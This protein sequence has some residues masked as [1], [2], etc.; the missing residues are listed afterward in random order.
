MD[1][2]DLDAK[3]QG[4]DN[5]FLI[6]LDNLGRQLSHGSHVAGIAA[7]I[8]NNAV[9]NGVAGV[10]WAARIHPKNIFDD[11]G[12]PD[13][14]QSIFDAVNFNANVWTLNNSWGLIQ[15]LDEFDNGIPGR[16]SVTVR[17]AFAHAY[18]NNRVSCIAM[19]NHQLVFGAGN[20]YANDVAFPAGFNTGSITVGA[21]NINDDIANFSAN[22]PH[23]DVAA[24]GV[25]IWSTNFNDNYIDLNGTSMATPYVAGLASLLK[26][27]N[28][29]LAND[30]IEQIIRLSADDANILTDPGFDNQ[31]GAGRIN[32]ER[33]LQ[34]LQAPNTLQQLSITGGTIN[35]T[36]GNMTRIF[37][38]V[39]GLA[40]AAY[41]VRGSEVRRNIAFPAMCNLIGVWGRGVGTTG[42]REE[43]GKVLVRAFAKLFREL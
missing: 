8:T 9:N 22:G 40:D 37:L 6:D 43:N 14:T 42:L 41:I 27:F 29:N 33:A 19:G 24:P 7:A 35:N 34:F 2:D 26:G 18:R 31:M 20:R 15:G 4:G 36:S 30:D 23:I 5:G 38:G 21:T 3:I 10:D 39:P 11:N 16:Y 25:G 13:I 12:D 17:S 1:H 28:I 32:A